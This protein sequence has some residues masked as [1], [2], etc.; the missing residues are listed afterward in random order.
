MIGS[1]IKRRDTM[2]LTATQKQAIAA[3]DDKARQILQQ[4]GEEELLMSLAH[5]MPQLKAIIDAASQDELN[6]Y[7]ERYDGFYQYMNLLERLAFASSQGAFDDL[8]K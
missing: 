4:G 2:T 6:F 7:C 1:P 5:K 3:L 8:K